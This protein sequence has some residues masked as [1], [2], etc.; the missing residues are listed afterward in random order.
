MTTYR[1]PYTGRDIPET[2]ARPPCPGAIGQRWRRWERGPSIIRIVDLR[3]D[4]ALGRWLF[5]YVPDDNPTAKHE[6]FHGESPWKPID[7][8]W[9][10]RGRS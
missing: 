4:P 3:W 9:P 5:G 1:S 6:Y 2:E 7:N 8:R 10:T